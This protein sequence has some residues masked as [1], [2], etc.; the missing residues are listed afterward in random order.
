LK[1]ILL[2]GLDGTGMLFKGILEVLPKALNIQVFCLDELEG[3]SYAKK[4]QYLAEHLQSTELFIVVESYSGPIAYELC[5][6]L[7]SNVKQIVFLASFISAPSSLSRCAHLIPTFALQASELNMWLLNKIGFAGAGSDSQ[8]LDV[9][10]SISFANKAKLKNRL[11]NISQLRKPQNPHAT[12]VV[13]I[14]P[15]NDILVNNRAVDEVKSVFN[16][17]KVI[18]ISGGHFIAQTNPIKCADI[19]KKEIYENK[20]TQYF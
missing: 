8:I 13:Y 12:P 17:T 3:D 18:T 4:A 14:K 10:K 1:I 11:Q 7:G 15:T 20:S 6:I 9:F 2:P 19:I 5:N 16:N